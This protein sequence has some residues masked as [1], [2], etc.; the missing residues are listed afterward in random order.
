MPLTGA[1]TYRIAR[2]R[3]GSSTREMR[4]TTFAP[5]RT[6]FNGS[7]SFKS[8][9]P[10]K[11]SVE[12]LSRTSEIR[13][14]WLWITKALHKCTR[15]PAIL[16]ILRPNFALKSHRHPNEASLQVL[17][18]NDKYFPFPVSCIDD[19]LQ[20]LEFTVSRNFG[21]ISNQLRHRKARLLS[22]IGE[23]FANSQLSVGRWL[24]RYN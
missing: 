6:E 12:T 4:L 19:T 3:I 9:F 23:P 18:R 13:C 20:K 1:K 2:R 22:W 14:L 10:R 24:I 5:E 7:C 17:Q 8:N 21:Y 11:L 15:R 16:Y